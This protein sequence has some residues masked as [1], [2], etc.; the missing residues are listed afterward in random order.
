MEFYK[1]RPFTGSLRGMHYRVEKT[2]EDGEVFFSA[3]VFPGPFSSENTPEEKKTTQRFPFTNQGLAD[4]VNWL[5]ERY[6]EEPEKWA[7]G[8]DLLGG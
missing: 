3:T 1:H 4:V 6:S 2:E 5:N 7:R 8:M